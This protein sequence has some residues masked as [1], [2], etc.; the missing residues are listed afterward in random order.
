MTSA[1]LPTLD[2]G[3]YWH[4]RP[5]VSDRIKVARPARRRLRDDVLRAAAGG[6]CRRHAAAA[7][8][9]AA[10][11]VRFPCS[12]IQRHALEAPNHYP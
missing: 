1:H 6:R 8:V 10:A 9:A 3:P 5:G 11:L 7:S 2:G 4:L 12:Q